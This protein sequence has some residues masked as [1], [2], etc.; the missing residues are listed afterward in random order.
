MDRSIHSARPPLA[1]HLLGCA[2]VLLA[3]APPVSALTAECAG[4]V[5]PNS[6]TPS[7]GAVCHVEAAGQS[8]DAGWTVV[9]DSNGIR[10]SGPLGCDSIYPAFERAWAWWQC[11]VYPVVEPYIEGHPLPVYM[12]NGT[13]YCDSPI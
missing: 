1:L 11:P 8:C 4:G 10:G 9:S 12:Y 2:A 5:D 13:E 6:P 7:A 3:L